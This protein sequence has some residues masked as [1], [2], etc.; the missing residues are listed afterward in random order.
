MIARHR[1]DGGRDLPA[2]WAREADGYLRFVDHTR[3]LWRLERRD[4]IERNLDSPRD[5]LTAN[6]LRLIAAGGFRR[7]QSKVDR[8]LADP[9]TRR[10]FAF[11]AMYAGVAPHDALGLYA[12]IAYL[13]SVEG[14]YFPRGGIHA[15]ARAL[16]AAAD[17]HGVTFQYGTT[18]E[19]VE[20][21]TGRASA[22]STADGER[23]DADAIVLNPDLPVA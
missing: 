1:P 10:V 14:V 7:L 18:V 9:R 22:S 12:V 13:D 20:V 17:K 21:R 4:F 6:L 3:R 23:I 11:Q 16:A 15:V 8:F 2:L 19:R 5:L